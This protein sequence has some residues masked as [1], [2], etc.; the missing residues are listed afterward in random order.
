[1]VMKQPTINYR[2]YKSYINKEQIPILIDSTNI[3]KG[4]RVIYFN[5]QNENETDFIRQ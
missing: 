3:N 5:P 2:L 4:F 1:M